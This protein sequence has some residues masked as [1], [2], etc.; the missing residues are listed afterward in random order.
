MLLEKQSAEIV[1]R[2]LLEHDDE[3]LVGDS[4]L[5]NIK[6]DV[7]FGVAQ[8]NRVLI[9]TYDRLIKQGVQPSDIY[10]KAINIERERIDRTIELM[11]KISNVF[12]D[13]GIDFI[14]MK[15]YQHYPDMGDDIDLFVMDHTGI[16]DS[17]IIEKLGAKPFKRTLL[18]RIGGKTQYSIDGYPSELEIHHG[19]MGPMGEQT[20]FPYFLM[21]NRKRMPF[22]NE[23][24]FVPST[25][26]QFVIQVL[27]RVYGR[28]YLRISELV[29]AVNCICSGTFD[30]DYIIETTV[31]I[32]IFDGLRYYVNCIEFIYENVMDRSLPPVKPELFVSE[33]TD[34]LRFKDFHYRLPLQTIAR[35]VYTR[36]IWSDIRASRW[37]AAG[38]TC[39]LPFFGALVTA[40]TIVN[41]KE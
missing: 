24:M 20:E 8:K 30:W 10:Q 2:L 27:Q 19:R 41:S 38:R 15:N 12:G 26:D 11:C 16:S 14:F 34:G 21:K 4:L 22:Q 18:N 6:W 3:S 23:E 7:L 35:N 39:L 40:K 32:G 13:A 36:K 17:L 1:L 33:S 37:K 25:E 31:S 29:Y 28:F 9:R 5:E